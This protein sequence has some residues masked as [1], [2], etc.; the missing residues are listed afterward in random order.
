[1]KLI[2]NTGIDL[3]LT[4][5]LQTV[6]LIVT[7]NFISCKKDVDLTNVI[8]ANANVVAYVNT[9]LLTVLSQYDFFGSGKVSRVIY[10]IRDILHN[11]EVD[12]LLDQFTEDINSL[13]LSLKGDC[14]VFT[15]MTSLGIILKVNNAEKFKQVLFT[16][17]VAN[18]ASIKLE[19]GVYTF[20]PD[21]D[22]FTIIWDNEKLLLLTPLNFHQLQNTVISVEDMAKKL[23]MQSSTE[24]INCNETFG[25]FMND[26]K[27]ISFFFSTKDLVQNCELS[28]LD[29]LQNIKKIWNKA[30]N[31]SASF[32]MLFAKGVIKLDGKVLLTAAEK[33][34]YKECS[35]TT[36]LKPVNLSI[37]QYNSPNSL[38]SIG[39]NTDGENIS[40]LF[41][42]LIGLISIEGR[43]ASQ[44]VQ[45]IQSVFIENAGN[46]SISVSQ[47]RRF[48]ELTRYD[49]GFFASPKYEITLPL[50]SIFSET[51][52]GEKLLA[53]MSNLDGYYI[54]KLEGDNYKIDFESAYFYYGLKDGLFYLTNI[55]SPA[56]DSQNIKTDRLDAVLDENKTLIIRGDVRE[57]LYYLEN[58]ENSFW[59]LSTDD[60]CLFI[61][62]FT[63]YSFTGQNMSGNGEIVMSVKGKNSFAFL[64]N[65]IDFLLG[66][67]MFRTDS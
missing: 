66:N 12:V 5:V 1:M 53:M 58:K 7:L 38:F 62:F 35:A 64:C 9:E 41:D 21:V 14:Y 49:D 3:K 34:I 23:F 26:R 51:K 32:N 29:L 60:L 25:E 24:S 17:A 45:I 67:L 43:I 42:L 48:P 11:E 47:V 22:L 61:P 50:F 8:P 15:D 46:I 65:Y 13:G 2:W 4:A 28:T 36:L 20:T 55:S 39:L 63:Q 18:E 52:N 40:S 44:L 16:F 19:N 59:N 57:F 27:D 6:L 10:A 30:D 54:R 33:E 56:E 37:M 31:F